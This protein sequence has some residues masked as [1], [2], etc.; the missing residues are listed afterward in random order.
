VAVTLLGVLLP[1]YDL[2]T[3]T[4]SEIGEQGSPFETAF[5]AINLLVAG[6]FLLFAFG[7]YRFS[8]ERNLSH[9]PAILL[10]FFAL[11]E[12]GVFVFEAPHPWHNMFGIASILGYLAP[13]ILA[14]TWPDARSLRSLRRVSIAAG[15]FLI[16]SLALNLSELFV[17]VPYVLE[18]IGIV[19]RTLFVFHLWCAYAAIA[20]WQSASQP[21]PQRP[22]N[23][24]LD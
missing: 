17:R 6:C 14:I 3:Q 19:Q 24:S 8:G 22:S 2:V 20:L 9:A 7:V 11:M 13:G 15:A 23:T 4:I 5:R 18:H 16:V 10:G 1:G 21:C 12:T